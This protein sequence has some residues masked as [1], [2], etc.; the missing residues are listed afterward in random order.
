[1]ARRKHT[2]ADTDY[3]V[4]GDGLQI[5][6]GWR[7]PQPVL[8]C[9]RLLMGGQIK[10]D[11]CTDAENPTRAL[12]FGTPEDPLYPLENA[13]PAPS[14]WVYDAAWFPRALFDDVW[15]N[16]P[17]STRNAWVYWFSTWVKSGVLLVAQETKP[18]WDL[19]YQNGW[20]AIRP[21]ARVAFDLPPGLDVPNERRPG[22]PSILFAK[23]Y[24]YDAVCAAFPFEAE[25]GHP[26]FT[27]WKAAA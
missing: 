7:T 15:E 10:F 3:K 6:D 1:M 22:G 19:A 5:R 26:G 18:A 24:K 12:Y 16:P 20:T 11:F 8:A 2:E 4:V 13:D 17:F 9:A 21:R 23:G 14:L 25:D 27:V